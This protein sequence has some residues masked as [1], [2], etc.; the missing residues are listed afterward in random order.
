MTWGLHVTVSGRV[1]MASTRNTR[2]DSTLIEGACLPP[3]G[4]PTT[5]RLREEYPNRCPSRGVPRKAP[6]NRVPR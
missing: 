1:E 6:R 5:S 4:A 3:F 2:N